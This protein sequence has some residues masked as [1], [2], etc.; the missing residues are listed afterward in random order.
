[1]TL[2]MIGSFSLALITSWAILKPLLDSR[3]ED[4]SESAEQGT[5]RSLVDRKERA[6]RALKD[7][8]LDHGMGKLNDDDYVRAKGA[9]SME[10]ATLLEEIKRHGGS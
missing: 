4:P 1:M 7:L 9:L 8:E 10:A 2:S 6:L 3:R 5:L